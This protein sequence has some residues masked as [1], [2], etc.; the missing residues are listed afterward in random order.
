MSLHTFKTNMYKGK[1]LLHSSTHN[2]TT[3]T[4]HYIQGYVHIRTR[5]RLCVELPHSSTHNRTTYTLRYIQGYVHIRTRLRLC[6]ELLHSSTHNRTTYTLRY[7]Q[8]YVHIRT[9]FRFEILRESI[10]TRLSVHLRIIYQLY[11]TDCYSTCE[12]S[13]VVTYCAS[14]YIQNF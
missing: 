13:C 9:R 8:G 10:V 6:V 4:L 7:I 1:Q 11:V 5:L 2:R 14:S 3:Y 12:F